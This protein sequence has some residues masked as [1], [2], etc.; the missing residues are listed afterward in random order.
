MAVSSGS[1]MARSRISSGTSSF[2][3]LCSLV[4]SLSGTQYLQ[5]TESR[6][7]IPRWSPR[8]FLKSIHTTSADPAQSVPSQLFLIIMLKYTDR[9]QRI[10]C[11]NMLSKCFAEQNVCL[12]C[13]NEWRGIST[14]FLVSAMIMR[15]TMKHGNKLTTPRKLTRRSRRLCVCRRCKAGDECPRTSRTC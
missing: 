10:L 9:P 5:T 1:Q 12:F 4:F 6:T 13:F 2:A 8:V 11:Q 3:A 15:T 7:S 14:S